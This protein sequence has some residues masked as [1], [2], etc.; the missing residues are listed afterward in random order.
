MSLPLLVVVAAE[1]P[2]ASWLCMF[3]MRPGR[4]A[5][6]VSPTAAACCRATT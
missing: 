1:E 3:W 4:R 5:R 6:F 2:V